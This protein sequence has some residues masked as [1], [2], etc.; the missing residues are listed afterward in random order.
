MKEGLEKY[1]GFYQ[2]PSIYPTAGEIDRGCARR[3]TRW[4][5][6]TAN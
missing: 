2:K 5:G 3:K 1:S 6:M 4:R